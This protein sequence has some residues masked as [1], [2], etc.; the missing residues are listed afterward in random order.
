MALFQVLCS[1]LIQNGLYFQSKRPNFITIGT[2]QWDILKLVQ[3]FLDIPLWLICQFSF[4]E[5]YLSQE[6]IWRKTKNFCDIFLPKNRMKSSH[7]IEFSNFGRNVK[8]KVRK[9]DRKSSTGPTILFDLPRY[10]RYR[11]SRVF[12]LKEVRNV[13][14]TEEFVRAIEKLEK[15]SIRVFESQLYV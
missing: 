14:R 15:L 2:E 11:D 3:G 9:N 5:R 12:L 4:Y 7:F 13:Q 10:S 6:N 8:T 1:F